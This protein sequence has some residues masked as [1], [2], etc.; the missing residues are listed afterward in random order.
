MQKITKA[1]IKQK[2]CLEIAADFVGE[3]KNVC[4][5]VVICPLGWEAKV[6]DLLDLLQG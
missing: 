4:S 3:I 1:P 5:G 2:A 6:P